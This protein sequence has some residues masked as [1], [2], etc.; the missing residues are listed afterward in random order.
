LKAETTGGRHYYKIKHPKVLTER[1]GLKGNFTYHPVM[2]EQFVLRFVNAAE[3]LQTQQVLQRYRVGSR[4]AFHLSLQDNDLMVQCNQTEALPI[5]T[6]IMI[7]NSTQT[8]I[9]FFDIF[10]RMDNLKSGYHHPDGMLWI[11]RPD[12][13]HVIHTQKIPL[14]SIA[15][16]ILEMYKVPKPDFMTCNPF[17]NMEILIPAS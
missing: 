4:S 7:E 5:S 15:P 9:P 2:A 1:L 12:R 13:E 3:A 17:A 14:H 16:A 8:T 10:Y 6:V 11:R